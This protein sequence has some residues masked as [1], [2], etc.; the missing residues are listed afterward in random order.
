MTQYHLRLL[1]SHDYAAMK[2]GNELDENWEFH[3][4]FDFP[5]EM[6]PSGTRTEILLVNLVHLSLRS[7]DQMI[8]KAR[9]LN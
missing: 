1:P 9:S 6:A 5:Q 3:D 4:S 2:G 7:E 8:H